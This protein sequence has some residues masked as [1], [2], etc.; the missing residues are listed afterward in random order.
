VCAR[1]D[2]LALQGH[3]R[4]LVPEFQASGETTGNVVKLA[5]PGLRG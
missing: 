1:G 3:L 4:R 2:E 5:R